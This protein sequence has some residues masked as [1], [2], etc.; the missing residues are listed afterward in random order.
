MAI[1]DDVKLAMRITTD[2]LDSLLESDIEACKI[3]LG[4]AG[5][6]LP[7]QMDDIIKRAIITYC[8]LQEGKAEDYD[9]LKRAYDEQKAQL[10]MSSGYTDYEE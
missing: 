9:R 4:I 1:L 8:Q 7:P 3:D 2:K 10:S 6:V 5:V